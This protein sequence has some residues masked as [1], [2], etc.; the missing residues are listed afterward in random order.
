MKKRPRLDANHAE[1]VSALRKMD[2]QVQSLA[3]IGGGCP[4]LLCSYRYYT[5]VVEIKDGRKAP[6][7]RKLTPAEWRWFDAWTGEYWVIESLDDCAQILTG[8]G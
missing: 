5:F 1:I 7:E 6:S 3:A 8:K 4:D 2:V